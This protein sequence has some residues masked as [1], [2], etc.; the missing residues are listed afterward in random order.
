MAKRKLTPK[1]NRNQT[2]HN[3]TPID[4][5]EKIYDP[6]RKPKSKN[7]KVIKKYPKERCSVKGCRNYAV[8][9]TDVCK[10]HGGDPVVKENLVLPDEI[11]PPLLLNNTKY[12]P[13]YHPMAF[14]EMSRDGLSDIEIAAKFEVAV[15]TIRNW[16]EKYAEFNTAYEVGQALHESWWLAEGKKNLDN[17]GYN[18]GLYKFLTGN[19]L[20]YSDKIESKNLNV[21]AGVLMVPGQVSIEEWEKGVK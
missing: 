11:L 9:K 2:D 13:S 7:C 3:D 8:G 16:A 18:T 12:N 10:K 6:N 4:P 17:R 21:T 20:G 15:T 19:K 1:K 14:I 5:D